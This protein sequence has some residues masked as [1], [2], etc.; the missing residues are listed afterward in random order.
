MLIRIRTVGII[1]GIFVQ[2]IV[3]CRS[4]RG[5]DGGI[6]RLE[7]TGL[8]VVRE[9]DVVVAI[10]KQR[11]KVRAVAQEAAENADEHAP[12]DIVSMVVLGR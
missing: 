10:V 1:V 9:R 12:D 3:Y 7:G 8:A 4:G 6:R 2:L 11:V 5:V